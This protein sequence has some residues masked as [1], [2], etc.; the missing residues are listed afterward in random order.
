MPRSHAV[1]FDIDGVLLHLTRQEET[2]FFD[3]FRQVAKV[4]ETHI[5]PDWNSYRV[6]NDVAIA[7]ELLE[8]QLGREPTHAEI[9]SVLDHYITSIEASLATGELVTSVIDGAGALLD[10]LGADTR[11]QLGLATANIEGAAVARLK[12]AGLWRGFTACGYAEAGGPKS[13]VL[14]AAIATLRDRDGNPVP[15]D[16]VV[17]LGDQL[18][19]LA[20]ARDNR[21][22]F[23]G[24]STKPEQREVLKSNGAEIVIANHDTTAGI[25]S[26]LLDL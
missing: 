26:D 16:R 3:A 23:I 18:G 17:F 7:G 9:R 6:R 19:D 10:L 25:I 24:V 12:H 15:S 1:I 20:A 22:H 8:R 13:E 14:R 21:V 2:R 5:N 11:L 4:S